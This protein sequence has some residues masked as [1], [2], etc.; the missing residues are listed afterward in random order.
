M[1]KDINIDMWHGDIF[2]PKKYRADAFFREQKSW[3]NPEHSYT[4]N[5]YNDEGKKIGDYTALNSTVVE[6]NFI[7]KWKD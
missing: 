6:E 5:I 3:H 4:G 2:E 1:Q 7:I